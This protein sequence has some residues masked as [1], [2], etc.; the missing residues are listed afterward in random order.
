MARTFTNNSGADIT[1]NEVGLIVKDYYGTTVGYFMIEHSALTFTVAN[2]TS[3][4]VT[5]T[6]SATV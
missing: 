1:V 6:I 4:T 2:G 3:G 5:Y